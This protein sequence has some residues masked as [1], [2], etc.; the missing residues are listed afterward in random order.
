MIAIRQRSDLWYS[1]SVVGQIS[2]CVL[3]LSIIRIS[4]IV[5]QEPSFKPPDRVYLQQESGSPMSVGC[6]ILDYTGEQIRFQ[7][8]PGSSVV[9]RPASQ[10]LRVDTPQLQTHVDGIRLLDSHRL[11]KA[12]EQFEKAL[13][14]ERREWVRREILAMLVRCGLR[15]GDYVNASERFAILLASDPKTRYFKLIPVCWSPVRIGA[16]E[17]LQVKPLL[18]D[19]KE[20]KRLVGASLL[21]RDPK[22]G[23]EAQTVMH[24]LAGSGDQRIASLARAQLWRLRVGASNL[25][26]AE[27]QRWEDSIATM[28]EDLRG[29]PHY[30][31]GQA[32]LFRRKYAEATAEFLWLPLVHFEDHYLAAR[33][34]IEAAETMKQTGKRRGAELLLRETMARFGHTPFGSEARQLLKEMKP[35]AQ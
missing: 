18:T 16:G 21:L 24:Q 2:F 10:V 26:E 35:Q 12:E 17:M 23:R 31:L 15:Q 11:R 30:V 34:S 20:A 9:T 32:F 22:Y 25:S 29:G 13:T 14:R 8:R 27:L 7:M 6:T 19:D 28:Q 4:S 5:A 3:L 33:A 1:T